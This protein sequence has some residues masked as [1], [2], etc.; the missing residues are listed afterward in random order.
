MSW[1]ERRSLLCDEAPWESRSTVEPIVSRRAA[2]AQ[3]ALRMVAHRE[4]ASLA[5]RFIRETCARQPI[6]REQP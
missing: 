1:N 3:G 6:G 2:T 4:S 5:E